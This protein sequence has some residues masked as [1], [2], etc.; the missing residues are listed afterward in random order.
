MTR[1]R[2][3]VP[4]VLL[5]WLS[6][7]AAFWPKPAL[8]GTTPRPLPALSALTFPGSPSRSLPFSPHALLAAHRFQK[9]ERN[10]A[11]LIMESADSLKMILIALLN[12]HDVRGQ[13]PQPASADQNGKP[14][15]SWRVAILPFIEQE[16]L[17]EQFKLNEPWDSE[18]NKKLLERMPKTFALPGAEEEAKKGLTHYRVFVGPGAAWEAGKAFPF[19]DFTDGLSNTWMV[20]VAKEAVPW[21]KPEELPFDPKKNMGALLGQVGGVFQA[22]FADGSVRNYPK[23]PNAKTIQALITRNGGEVIDD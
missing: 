13:F 22:A 7:T 5:A 11:A 9:A 10:K 15:L 1:R 2:F 14:L 19:T 12:H 16:A 3:A 4:G 8:S 20:V 18:H 17:Y 21:T 6:A 23:L